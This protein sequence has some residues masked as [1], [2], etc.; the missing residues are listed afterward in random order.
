MN[1]WKNTRLFPPGIDAANQNGQYP[2]QKPGDIPTWE[3]R[4]E[5]DEGTE[6]LAP[7]GS[8]YRC[9]ESH[10]ASEDF[11]SDSTYWEVFG[12][13]GVDT[14]DQLLGKVDDDLVLSGGTNG[15]VPIPNSVVDMNAFAY[16]W[17]TCGKPL[18][19]FTVTDTVAVCRWN[20]VSYDKLSLPLQKIADLIPAVAPTKSGKA[21]VANFSGTP[22]KASVTFATAF[23]DAD[24]TPNVSVV[25][26][27]NYS[28]SVED[29]TPAGFTI[30]LNSDVAP[31]VDL[32]WSAVKHGEY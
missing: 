15:G 16:L 29:I 3:P 17:E 24:Y 31:S 14:N 7:D 30:N 1:W 32:Y 12:G 21:I 4:F 22:K 10:I 11:D 5:Y 28:V 13:P 23:A 25:T 20:G 18:T 19:D 26:P 8:Y 27:D 2:G 6:V 9:I